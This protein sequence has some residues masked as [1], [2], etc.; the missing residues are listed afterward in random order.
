[1]APKATPMIQNQY[2]SAWLTR[3]VGWSLL[4]GGV[5][6]ATV[7]LEAIGLEAGAGFIA[8]AGAQEFDFGTGP[9][10][11]GGNAMAE[12]EITIVGRQ[13]TAVIRNTSPDLDNYGGNSSLL[14]PAISAFGFDLVGSSGESLVLEDWS[15]TA[16]KNSGRTRTLS[17]AANPKWETST[18]GDTFS[19]DTINDKNGLYNSGA[20]GGLMNSLKNAKFTEAVL[21]LTFNDT[22][23]LVDGG[24]GGNDPG[25]NDPGGNDPGGSDPGGSDPG[26]GGTVNLIEDI[27]E[28]FTPFVR[29]GYVGSALTP[30]TFTIYA[31]PSDTGGTQYQNP[32]PS[33]ILIWALGFAAC[34]GIK[35][36]RKN[37]QLS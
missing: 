24:P 29:F 1:M 3:I 28:P 21:E 2:H 16:Y 30:Q 12:I 9:V 22:V 13:L 36:P 37:I 11:G 6:L 5:G 20:S 33:S 10:A 27:P 18:S 19:F 17:D 25:G 26:P 35:R 14:S 32:E 7:G 15:L 34:V 23:A 31:P 4:I 8:T